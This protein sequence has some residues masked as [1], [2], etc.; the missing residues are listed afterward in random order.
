MT[1]VVARQVQFVGS[2]RRVGAVLIALSCAMAI[3]A[4]SAPAVRSA[5]SVSLP[6]T[7][8]HAAPTESNAGSAELPA[9]AT[10][11]VSQTLG[12]ADHSYWARHS[13]T[14]RSVS[15]VNHAQGFTA[16]LSDS[17]VGLWAGTS[18]VGLSLTGVGRSDALRA[19]A[20]VAPSAS[21]NVVT[22]EQ[23]GLT[24]TYVN[25]PAGLEQTFTLAQRPTATGQVH[26]A[27]A[28]R[29]SVPRL[30]GSTVQLPVAGGTGLTYGGLSVTDATGRVLSSSLQVTAGRIV[31]E[32]ADA[33][34]VYP[35]HVDPMIQMGNKLFANDE[36]GGGGQFGVSVSLSADGNTALVGGNA[37]N[38]YAGA[39]WVFTRS[40]TTWNQQGPKLTGAGETAGG[41]FGFSVALSA[42]GNTAL[43]GGFA[44][45]SYA[46]AAWVFTRS[47]TSWSQQGGKLTGAGESSVGEFGGSVALS[48]DGNTALIGGWHDSSS[49]GA[50]WV[51]T[52][53]GASWS[54]QGNKLAATATDETGTGNFGHSVA[55][56]ADGNT[57][58]IGGWNDNSGAGAA[59]V[60][61]RIG[62]TWSQQGPKLTGAGETSGG[63]FGYS[64]ALSADG[65]TALIGGWRDSSNTGAAWVFT[66][67][68]TVWGQQGPKL[69]ATDETGTGNFGGSVAL[70]ADGNTA[71]ISG[72]SDNQSVGAAWVFTRTGTT[73]NQN[74]SRLTGIGENG[75]GEFGY[76]AALSGD[77]N[78]AVIGGAADS[79]ATGAVWMFNGAALQSPSS[80]TFGSQTVA[81]PGAVQWIPVQNTG[82]VPVTFT[83]T[84]GIVGANAAEFSIPAGD[85]LCSGQTLTAGSTCLIGVRFTPS[86]AGQRTATLSAPASDAFR[87]SAPI[88]LS[89]AGVAVSALPTPPKIL[90][91]R[92]QRHTTSKSK[93]TIRYTLSTAATVTCKVQ[94]AKSKKSYT[95]FAHWHIKAGTTTVTWNRKLRGKA[96][97]K[98]TYILILTATAA[99]RSITKKVTV[100]L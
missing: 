75:N 17:G 98:G 74:G 9:A 6:W 37:D 7:A 2:Q 31:L 83:G 46:G 57:A 77:G 62:A 54:Q 72:D 96:A 78:T 71:L 89:G 10:G 11:V 29:G 24:S 90:N 70:S 20:R 26:I 94:R 63:Q 33:A 39:A 36:T 23:P 76:S 65:N 38:S 60:L 16:T 53:N 1:A 44:D 93:V 50:A 22:Y 27:L 14:S 58:L 30:N 4:Q 47:G 59:W 80:Q 66:R 41:Q 82:L 95:V 3:V 64:V 67:S 69:T 92:I 43:I 86:T 51:F 12:S 55:L 42:D 85:D 15:L 100:K 87:A 99:G 52:R 5:I 81:T 49:A 45:N 61:T 34:A 88:M 40:G 13:A 25:G 19:P 8:P 18:T 91:L 97:P 56:S 35:I 48:A 28:V 79:S 73:W 32:F 84:S 21:Q 68:A